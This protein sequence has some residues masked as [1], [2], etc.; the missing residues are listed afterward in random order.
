MPLLRLVTIILAL[1]AVPA[2][3][4]SDPSAA[5]DPS[6]ADWQQVIQAQVQAFRDHDAA[7]AFSY[8][9]AQFHTQFK[10][11]EDFFL[12]IVNAGYA[13]MMESQSESFGPYEQPTPDT[14]LQD[15]K[16]VGQDQNFYEAI[17]QL[18]KEAG[19]WRI[20]AVQLGK[21]PGSAA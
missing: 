18:T 15:V 2:L 20:V 10:D 7:A 3:A 19:G 11:P 21:A 13:P 5:P 4:Q 12:A 6:A 1:L 9:A 8:S 17:Y 16:F 14:V